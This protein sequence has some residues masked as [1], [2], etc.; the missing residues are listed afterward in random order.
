MKRRQMLNF[1]QLELDAGRREWKNLPLVEF[2][3]LTATL[4][5]NGVK[6]VSD[7]RRHL[8]YVRLL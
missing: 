2:N 7:Y 4:R 6:Y 5:Q 1:Y 8:Y 3:F